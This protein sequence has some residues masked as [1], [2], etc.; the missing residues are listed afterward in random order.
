VRVPANAIAIALLEAAGVPI[1]APSA[2]R[3]GHISPTTAAHVL[4]DLG[5]HPIG[6]LDPEAPL[7]G[8]DDASA[9]IPRDTVC[10]VGIESTVVGVGSGGR[11]LS[12]FRRGGA[13]IEALQAALDAAGITGVKIEVVGRAAQS[14]SQA[15]DA[16]A[17]SASAAASARTPGSPSAEKPASA[18][19]SAAPSAG[20]ALHADASE[21]LAAPGQLL[22]HYAP[23]VPA[24]L[25]AGLA[26]T[27]SP[28][29]SVPSGSAWALQPLEGSRVG[30]QALSSTVVLD[31]CGHIRG[32]VPR[33]SG[34]IGALAYGELDR[35]DADWAIGSAAMAACTDSGTATEAETSA[36]EA[37][38]S[39]GAEAPITVC[40]RAVFAA[41]RWAEA[42]P[43]ARAVLLCDPLAV[44][45]IGH[46][47]GADSLRDR[48]FRAAS[49]GFAR[50]S[51]VE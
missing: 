3:F 1:A 42:V 48:L 15:P 31:I 46:T 39:S 50:L 22:T 10:A 11:T 17:A 18:T 24:A 23:D 19:A 45:G 51:R 33:G 16:T 38:R 29:G 8:T 25:C 13:P 9:V 40:Q 35:A 28:G 37:S 2:N 44:T 41:L 21:P 12:V 43:G 4:A 30:A 34:G 47:S 6:V 20:A 7:A 49:G 36:S 14:Q 32:L 5:A 26:E 27:S